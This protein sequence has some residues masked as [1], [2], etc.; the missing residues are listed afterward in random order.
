MSIIILLLFKK[1]PQ[2]RFIRIRILLVYAMA[3]IAV[4]YIL[5]CAPKS[6][7]VLYILAVVVPCML[8]V[9]LFVAV[10]DLAYCSWNATP[11]RKLRAFL[12]CTSD[13]SGDGGQ[14]AVP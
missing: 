11:I 14:Q 9:Q 10:K 2:H 13:S 1:D 3:M 7:Y 6:E 5:G 12:S 8:L 4:V